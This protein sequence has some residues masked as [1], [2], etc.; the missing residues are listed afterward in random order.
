MNDAKREPKGGSELPETE[1]EGSEPVSVTI[2]SLD[3]TAKNIKKK[4]QKA[5]IRDDHQ[6]KSDRKLS[7]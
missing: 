1:P 2:A 3:R 6:L 4:N 7:R 5:G